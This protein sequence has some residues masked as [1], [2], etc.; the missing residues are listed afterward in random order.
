MPQIALL[1]CTCQNSRYIQSFI[2]IPV[3][4]KCISDLLA[5]RSLYT[6]CRAPVLDGCIPIS[7]SSLAIDKCPMI[8]QVSNLKN[9]FG[10]CNAGDD[11]NAQL[12]MDHQSQNAHH[13]GTSLV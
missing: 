3:T 1:L 11:R 6:A 4:N 2:Q 9:I 8:G 12:F 13:G 10:L 5:T 7:F